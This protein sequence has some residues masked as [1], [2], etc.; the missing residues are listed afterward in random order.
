[1]QIQIKENKD[2]QIHKHW[3]TIREL[4][5]DTELE[6]KSELESDTE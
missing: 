3:T 4:E 1:M 2:N 5:S 6:L